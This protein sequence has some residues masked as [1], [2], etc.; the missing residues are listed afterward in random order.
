MFVGT[1]HP[2]TDGRV[3]PFSAR[4]VGHLSSCSSFGHRPVGHGPSAMEGSRVADT[5]IPD[6]SGLDGN[7]SR[8]MVGWLPR[9]RIH[10][11][12]PSHRHAPSLHPCH[13]LSNLGN[14]SAASGVAYHVVDLSGECPADVFIHC[15]ALGRNQ[16]EFV[17]GHGIPTN[18][19]L[20]GITSVQVRQWTLIGAAILPLMLFAEFLQQGALIAPPL[21]VI[22][23]T[24]CQPGDKKHRHPRRVLTTLF[25]VSCCGVVGRMVLWNRL[26]LPLA[27]VMPLTWALA[28]SVMR[29]THVIMPPLAATSLL[30]FAIPGDVSLFPVFATFGGAYLMV[31]ARTDVRRFLRHGMVV[32]V[33]RTSYNSHRL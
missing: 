32:L 21:L 8:H 12:I 31:C 20:G 1:D 9:H 17:P 14:M 3:G 13:F 10:N 23:I 33:Q 11:L 18:S 2:R 7:S 4:Q 28:F 6:C 30:P 15:V 24:L 5:G 26:A 16:P 19:R 25:L 22:F 27:I 29:V